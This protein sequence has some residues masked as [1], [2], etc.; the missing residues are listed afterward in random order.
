MNT[1]KKDFRH[2]TSKI[3]VI[4]PEAKTFIDYERMLK[5]VTKATSE[6]QWKKL[7][8]NIVNT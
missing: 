7:A 4:T 8:L 3:S 6:K 5:Q 1:K 2:H